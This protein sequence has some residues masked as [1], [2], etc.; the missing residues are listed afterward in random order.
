[1]DPKYD[2]AL[3]PLVVSTSEAVAC[4][5]L[6]FY[7]AY[8]RCRR[9]TTGRRADENGTV[10]TPALELSFVAGEL[11]SAGRAGKRV[12]LRVSKSVL[13]NPKKLFAAAKDKLSTS[14][15]I[16]RHQAQSELES[17]V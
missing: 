3:W 8:R 6:T 17:A 2:D 5:A 15:K 11:T 9:K 13:E 4:W 14:R 16:K 7:I 12:L 1:M 10:V